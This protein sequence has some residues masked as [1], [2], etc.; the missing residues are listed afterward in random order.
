MCATKQAESKEKDEFFSYAL[1][2]AYEAE[3]P[4]QNLKKA[5]ELFFAFKANWKIGLYNELGLIELSS[6]L[7]AKE[8][9][10]K[11]SQ[12]GVVDAKVRL[13]VWKFLGIETIEEADSSSKR[14][15][16]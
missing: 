10:E 11:A 14:N 1:A 2:R 16:L 13:A 4:Y 3:G 8:A 5:Y 6:L 9:Y 15:A 7:N 12:N